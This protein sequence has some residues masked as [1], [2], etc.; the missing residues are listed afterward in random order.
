MWKCGE[1]TGFPLLSEQHPREQGLKQST[2]VISITLTSPFRATSKRTRIETRLEELQFH[3]FVRLSEQ[4]PREQGL[5]LYLCG[6][7]IPTTNTFRATSKRTRIETYQSHT[8][9]LLRFPFQSNILENKDW[10][11]WSFWQGEPSRWLSEQHPREQGLKLC[12]VLE[13]ICIRSPTFRATSKRTRIETS[14][15]QDILRGVC[16]LSEQHPREQGLKRCLWCF[17]GKPVNTF[18]ATSKRTRIET[19]LRGLRTVAVWVLSEQHPREQ[20]LKL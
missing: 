2:S 18:R 10:N 6:R 20:G 1:V 15:L 9:S 11:Q 13:K 14:K 8:L 16:A 17:A 12:T 5:K 3:I 4:H 7:S 19:S